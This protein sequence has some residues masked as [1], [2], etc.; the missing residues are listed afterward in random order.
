MDEFIIQLLEMFHEAKLKWPSLE[1]IKIDD[2]KLD[3]DLNVDFA[4]N[5]VNSK[6]VALD[7]I[8]GVPKFYLPTEDKLSDRNNFV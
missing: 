6:S 4:H 2:L 8:V 3:Q 5:F 1:N 7:K